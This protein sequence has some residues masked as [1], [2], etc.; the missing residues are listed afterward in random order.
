MHFASSSLLRSLAVQLLCTYVAALILTIGSI[1]GV[2]WFGTGQV[3]GVTSQVQLRKV[4]ELI[5][6][7]IRFDSGGAPVRVVSLPSDLSWVFHDFAADVKYRILDRS[8]HVMVSSET[9]AAVLAPPGQPFDST[10][11]SFTLNSGGE[12]LLVRTEPAMH[13]T[14]TYYVQVAISKRF[15]TFVRTVTARV[16][17]SDTLKFALAS[18]VLV[19]VAVY[20]TL[21]RVLKPLRATSAAAAG[22]DARSISKRLS[23]QNIPIEFLPVVEAFNL[24]LERLE[25]GYNVQRSFLADAAHE[26][27]TPLAL[28]RAQIDVDGTTDR[29]VLLHD[30]DFMARQINQ[31]LHLAEASETQNYV[32]ESVDVAAVVEDV[33]DYLRRLAERREVYL[34][35]RCVPRTVVLE[36]DKGALFMLLKNLVENSIQHSPI[37]G[38]VG[39]KVDTEHLCIRDE[40]PGIAA[41]ELPKLF[42]RFW[43]GPTR[44]N[45]GAGLGLSICAEIAAAHEWE[46]TARSTGRGAEFKLSFRGGARKT[47]A[48]GGVG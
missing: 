42:R 23:T 47:S 20:F 34:D 45:E 12:T 3:A 6:A 17:V 1:A 37:G 26:L 39:V 7:G 15:S 5:E 11:G 30:L 48:E 14:Q 18:V 10:R 4:A 28:V 16:R 40:G 24:T 19:T 21:R 36:A 29:S 31:L 33:A 25:K 32:F 8:G 46:L 41:D 27:K 35:I 44:R 43:R 38:I 22:I 9:D 13:G 2:I